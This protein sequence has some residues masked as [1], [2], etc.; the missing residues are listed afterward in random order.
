MRI[1]V[2]T[3]K[4]REDQSAS[5]RKYHLGSVR[6]DLENM[7]KIRCTL[8]II[9]A[10]SPSRPSSPLK[11]FVSFAKDL[12]EGTGHVAETVGLS[13]PTRAQEIVIEIEMIESSKCNIRCNLSQCKMMWLRES[14]AEG[15]GPDSGQRQ[16]MTEP[17]ASG[18][19]WKL[20]G[21]GTKTVKMCNHVLVKEHWKKECVCTEQQ[22]APSQCHG[23]R[24][25]CLKR[26]MPAMRGSHC[27]QTGV[28]DS[29]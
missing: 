3:K 7:R 28:T 27:W 12:G 6:K 21:G 23:R 25:A 24:G 2:P 19:R 20:F 1:K 22:N 11:I 18:K 26:R 29:P 14:R 17:F 15:E 10:S 16:S 8:C 13:E 5:E 4:M 9:F